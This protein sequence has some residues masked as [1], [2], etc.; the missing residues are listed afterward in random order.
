MLPLLAGQIGNL[1]SYSELASICN[2]DVGTVNAYIEIMEESHIVKR[3]RP[4]A[5]GK[6][7]EIT[8]APKTF[9]IDNGI[10]N[11]LLNNFSHELPL[12]TD[13]GQ[14]FEN[15][16]FSEIYKNL[17]LQSSVKFWRSKTRAE[18]N[19]VI[20]HAGALSGLEVKC[21]SFKA[22]KVSLS[23]WSFMEA[24]HPDRFAVLNLTLEQDAEIKGREVSFITPLTFNRWLE[25]VFA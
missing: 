21:S 18:V 2:I 24:Y 3:L 1:M 17:P 19:F 15:W 7:R 20:E 25:S 6:R 22:P 13:K 4:F 14:L 10:R 23:L 8:G 16:A 5:G 9:F 11:Q 12:R